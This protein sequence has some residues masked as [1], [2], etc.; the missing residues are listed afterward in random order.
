LLDPPAR[1]P[2]AVAHSGPGSGALAMAGPMRDRLLELLEPCVHAL[3]F[4]L[5]DVECRVGHGH[6][7]GLVRLY[8][9]RPGGGVTLDDCG[10]V[11]GQVSGV[12][13]VEDVIRGSYVL[14]VSSPGEDRVLRTRAHL[15]AHCGQR[16]CVRLTRL[17]EGRRR[18]TGTL[19][20]LEGEELVMDVDN[21]LLRV[22]MNAVEQVRLAPQP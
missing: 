2:L 11:S 17:L 20:A 10:H 22:P 3:G 6:G 7:R 18:V 9:D 16:V 15:E 12:L 1:G 4:E 21:V 19:R 8:I 14:E 5:I 13:D